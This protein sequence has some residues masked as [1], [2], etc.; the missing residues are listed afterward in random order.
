MKN[1]VLVVDDDIFNLTVA[2][3]LLEKSYEV[4]AVSSGKQAL[5]F[6]EKKRP[7][8]ML[9]D[10]VMPEMDGFE[11]MRLVKE[12]PKWESIPVIFLT[13][14]QEPDMEVR[15]LE[16]GAV[17]F[18]GK[19]FE[20]RIM[21]SR[22]GHSI[23]LSHLQQKLKFIIQEKTL[24]LEEQQY[25][26]TREIA[27]IVEG[28][29]K[30]TG[31]H[32]QRTSSYVQFIIEQLRRAGEF[33]EELDQTAQN[34][35]V[36]AAALHDIGKIQISDLILN[37]PGRLTEEEYE[38]MKL[39]VDYGREMVERLLRNAEDQ[40]YYRIT[41]D[42]VCFHHERW[43]GSGY[44][45]GL[46]GRAIPLCARIMAVADV[47]DALTSE[48]CYKKPM[49]VSDALNIIRESAGKGLDPVI[50]RVF[51]ENFSDKVMFTTAFSSKK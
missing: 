25:E 50:V 31:G 23:E 27:E 51:L 41:I 7:D 26:F 44:L 48:R 16:A 10:I 5:E 11:L 17:D 13:A 18:I 8:L 36:R 22:V 45:A 20:P 42:L 1:L 37:K 38:Q 39:H 15:G 2:K 9:L 21:L 3:N 32:V 28:R 19:P 35:I 47:F 34:R 4:I 33:R 30:N 49:P 43:D 6:L 29:D 40:E 12:N 46:K 24:L 14:N